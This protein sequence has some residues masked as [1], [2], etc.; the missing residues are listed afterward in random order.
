MNKATMTQRRPFYN[1]FLK[2]VLILLIPLTL[3][4]GMFAY[5]V[6]K[7]VLKDYEVMN[8]QLIESITNG[9]DLSVTSQ[10]NQAYSLRT[11]SSLKQLSAN[12]LSKGVE[13]QTAYNE[14]RTLLLSNMYNELAQT[15]AVY[16]PEHDRVVSTDGS[17]STAED[18]YT[19]YVGFNGMS[20]DEFWT[21]VQGIDDHVYIPAAKATPAFKSR[22]SMITYVQ[23]ISLGYVKPRA[24][25]IAFIT[26]STLCDRV[27]GNFEGNAQFRLFDEEGSEL[28]RSSGITDSWVESSGAT[29]VNDPESGKYRI[30]TPSRLSCGLRFTFYVPESTVVHSVSLFVLICIIAIVVC[31]MVGLLLANRLA[32]QLYLPYRD[33]LTTSFPEGLGE[34]PANMGDGFKL[35]EGRLIE[36]RHLNSRFQEEIRN[37]Y[38]TSRD[39]ALINLMIRSVYLS[40]EEIHEAADLCKLPLAN[41]YYY[42]IALFKST[43]AEF[44]MPKVDFTSDDDC[45]LLTAQLSS[46]QFVAVAARAGNDS[47]DPLNQLIEECKDSFDIGLSNIHTSIRDLSRCIAEA[48][49]DC[50]KEKTAAAPHDLFYPIER[51]L[52][53]IAAARDGQYKDVCSLLTDLRNY[54]LSG[55]D[56]N[57]ELEKALYDHMCATALKATDQLSADLRGSFEADAQALMN[58]S[59]IGDECF[60]GILSLYEKLCNL[61]YSDI[62]KKNQAIIENVREYLSSNYA[63]V[64]L[65]LDNVADHLGVSYYFLSRIFKSE[66]NQSFTDMLGDVRVQHAMDLLRTTQLSVQ[67]ICTSVGYTNWSTFLRAFRKRAGTTPL[68]YRKMYCK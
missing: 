13:T 17:V 54:N 6:E 38:A 15:V 7:V 67:D 36:T 48:D 62:H 2:M 10:I 43:S 42:Q 58:G 35:I 14:L 52:Q 41:H 4:M 50:G 30:F 55:D 18:F 24:Y 1:L 23:P 65:C 22:C 27:L 64:S 11:L 39:N 5:A 61:T 31:I 56:S 68:Q 16:F 51:E 53:I 12:L 28:Y 19:R 40:D 32:K 3:V 46:R 9:I 37:Y 21:F 47:P 25:Y 34:R 60:A 63:D 59:K 57:S 26:E 49:A 44:E 33:L 45:T 29:S 20:S 8:T 66:T